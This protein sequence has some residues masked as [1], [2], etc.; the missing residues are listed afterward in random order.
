MLS[1]A[2]HAHAI[3]A[4]P[5]LLV[6]GQLCGRFVVVPGQLCGRFV[7]VPLVHRYHASSADSALHSLQEVMCDMIGV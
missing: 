4:M 5:L 7:V 2:V 6:H 3:S 1:L